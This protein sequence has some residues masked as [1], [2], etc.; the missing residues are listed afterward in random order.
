MLSA[1]AQRACR[2][3]HH[4]P[5]ALDWVWIGFELAFGSAPIVDSI[6]KTGFDLLISFFIEPVFRPAHIELVAGLGIVGVA[7]PQDPILRILRLPLVLLLSAALPALEC[8]DH[9][10]EPA[11]DRGLVA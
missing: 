9:P 4:P 1:L 11:L 5:T 2:S 3:T 7:R 10:I 8:H 6:D